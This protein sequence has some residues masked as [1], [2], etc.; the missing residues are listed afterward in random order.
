MFLY[1]DDAAVFI[2]PTRRDLQATTYIMQ[3]F[4]DASGLLTQ[5]G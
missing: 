2:N 3:L 5:H 4:A 1:A